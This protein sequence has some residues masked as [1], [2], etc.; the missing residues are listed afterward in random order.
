MRWHMYID[1][2]SSGNPGQSGAGLVVFDEENRELLRDSLFL[3]HMTNN[4]AEYEALLFALKKAK[5]AGII[6]ASVYTDSLL[7]ANQV[8][9]K[10]KIKNDV[11][12]A[13]VAAI[14][15]IIGNFRYFTIQY[16]PRERNGIADKL[17]KEAIRRG[18]RGVDG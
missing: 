12:R 18:A 14:K 2:A 15:N 9:G 1:G 7:L 10:F 6:E 13:Y 4:M 11:L 5:E 17:A 16:I 8:M 3:G